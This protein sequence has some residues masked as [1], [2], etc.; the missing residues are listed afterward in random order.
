MPCSKRLRL[1]IHNFR[2]GMTQNFDTLGLSFGL[3][4]KSSSQT[5]GQL[6][7]QMLLGSQ[8]ILLCRSQLT[9]MVS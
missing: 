9:K 6:L 2:K 4:L 8:R 1:L 5:A 7:S 3:M